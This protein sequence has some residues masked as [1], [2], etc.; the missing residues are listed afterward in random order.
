M[1]GRGRPQRV[2]E[3]GPSGYSDLAVGPDRTIY[4]FYEKGAAKQNHFYPGSLTLARLSLAWLTTPE[5][6]PR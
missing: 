2:L 5:P 6:I 3:P 4:C 1:A